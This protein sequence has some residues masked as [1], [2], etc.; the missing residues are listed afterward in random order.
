MQQETVVGSSY[1]KVVTMENLNLCCPLSPSNSEAEDIISKLQTNPINVFW[2]RKCMENVRA[3]SQ[4][5][6]FPF[7]REWSVNYSGNSAA[8][9]G[10]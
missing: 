6:L 5:D 7:P 10:G 4:R 1:I 9:M 2:W 8:E 3:S